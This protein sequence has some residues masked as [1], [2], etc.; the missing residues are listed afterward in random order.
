MYQRVYGKPIRPLPE[1]LI[2]R[3]GGTGNELNANNVNINFDFGRPVQT[4]YFHFGE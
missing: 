2:A 3:A 1:F 4:I